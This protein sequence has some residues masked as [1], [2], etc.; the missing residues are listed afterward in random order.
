MAEAAIDFRG[1]SKSF[2]SA[3]AIKDVSFTIKQVELRDSWEK[4]E[5]VRIHVYVDSLV[6][7]SQRWRR[8]HFQQSI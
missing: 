6:L 2:G 7:L 1:F 8:T 3:A 4:M 5:Q